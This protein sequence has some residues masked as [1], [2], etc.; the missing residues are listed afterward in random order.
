MV[1]GYSENTV[2]ILLDLAN[3]LAL[4]KHLTKMLHGLVQPLMCVLPTCAQYSMMT[5]RIKAN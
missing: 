4:M 2:K 1:K 3:Y 5:K